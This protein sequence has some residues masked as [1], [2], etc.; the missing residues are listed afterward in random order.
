MACGDLPEM[1][2]TKATAPKITRAIAKARATATPFGI[3]T[4]PGR[5]MAATPSTAVPDARKAC[6][7]Y[8]EWATICSSASGNSASPHCR[9]MNPICATV[10]HASEVFTADWVSITSPPNSAV[11]PPIITRSARTPGASSITS[12]KRIS[13]KP[14]ALM[15]P[16][17]SR[18]DTGVGVSMTS[19]SQPCIG[20][21]ADFRTAARARAAAIHMAVFPPSPSLAAAR[22]S[23]MSPV[24]YPA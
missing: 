6:A 13:R 5:R 23:A 10:D 1:P 22:I 20:N 24:P 9:I 18:A 11:N 8:S 3:A 2:K 15:T 14:P 19:V 12:A 16:A 21:C 17:W 4:G 7:L